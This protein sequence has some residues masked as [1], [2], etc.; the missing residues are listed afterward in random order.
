M[1]APLCPKHNIELEDEDCTRCGG[2]GEVEVD[3]FGFDEIETCWVCGG[4]GFFPHSRCGDCEEEYYN[5]KA[6]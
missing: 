2:S 4:R 5:E 6:Y 3:D 1:K